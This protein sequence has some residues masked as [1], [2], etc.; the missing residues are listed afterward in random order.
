MMVCVCGDPSIGLI[1]CED[2]DMF[3]VGRMHCSEVVREQKTVKC[4]GDQVMCF[5]FSEV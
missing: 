2:V 4:K 5:Y 3:V 1:M